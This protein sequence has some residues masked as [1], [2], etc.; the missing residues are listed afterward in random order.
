MLARQALRETA[1]PALAARRI[2]R[3]PGD[4][5]AL[6]SAIG[7]RAFC[8]LIARD[9]RAKVK[10]ATKTPKIDY[11][12]AEKQ[13]KAYAAP[14][15]ETAIRGLGWEGK[16]A[17]VAPDLDAL[18]KAG[19]YNEFADAVAALQDKQGA[20]GKAVDGM[21]GPGT[22][23]K[24]AGLGE[25]MASI[26]V[27]KDTEG[28]CYMATQRRFEG[29][30]PRATGSSFKLP[31]GSKT[32]VFDAIISTSIKDIKL[33]EEKYRATGAA[34]ALVYAG[35][36]TFVSEADIWAGKLKPGAA[37][38]VWAD[39]SAYELLVKGE[40]TD[41]KGKARAITKD[42]ANFL[43]TSYVFL[44]YEGANNEKVVVRHHSGVEVHPKSD[45][46]VWI[47]ANPD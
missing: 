4:H 24:L 12:E 35:K 16:L 5:A 30:T 38:Q 13:N 26:P 1:H 2:A 22:W 14:A 8:A 45:W 18:W 37:M 40:T 17:T 25:A 3:R 10:P 33:V 21:L 27:V 32:K 11:A 20:K 7:N 29:G 46:A 15:T 43:G 36:G 34:G 31:K 9:D 39:K 28:L 47:A 6:A 41:A 42:D 19:K 44:R 23:S